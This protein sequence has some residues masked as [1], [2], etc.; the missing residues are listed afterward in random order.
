V[1]VVEHDDFLDLLATDSAAIVAAGRRGDPAARVPGCPDWRLDDLIWHVGG[2]YHFWEYV[3][4]THVPPVDYV[5]PTRPGAHDELLAWLDERAAA[6]HAQL[7]DQDPATT[8]WTWSSGDDIAWI[9]RRMAHETAVHRVDAEAATGIEFRIAAE[10]AADG[11]DEFLAYFL[12]RDFAGAD[13][14]TSEPVLLGGSVHLHCT[15]TDGEWTVVDGPTGGYLVT[16]EHA[17]GDAAI[18]GEADALFQ[19][20]WGRRTLATVTVFGDEAVA[21]RLVAAAST[22]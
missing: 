14:Q 3:A 13:S 16:R 15:D 17:N 18:R 19:V 6:L 4:R 11:I 10:V 2:A 5:E 9:A 22:D 20:L 21:T 7:A 1:T 8:V 12:G